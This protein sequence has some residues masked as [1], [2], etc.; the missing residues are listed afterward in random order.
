MLNLD[1][2][3]FRDSVERTIMDGF[4]I[5]SEGQALIAEISDGVFGVRPS[6]GAAGEVFA[7]VSIY[8]T[9]TTE[10]MPEVVDGAVDVSLQL[11]LPHE[12]IAGSLRV[13][14]AAGSTIVVTT[15]YTIAGKVITLVSG[16]EGD[17]IQ[18]RYKF[19]PSV[20]EA[21]LLQGD[22]APG[23]SASAFL[24]QIGVVERG[25]VYTTEYDTAADWSGVNPAVKLGAGGLFTTAGS[26]VAVDCYVIQ[27]PTAA[28]PTLG[29]SLQ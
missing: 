14:N 18:A 2:S 4:S 25:D 17:V 5:A 11:T 28:D 8:Q 24:S 29:L 27:V 10:V 21:L 12:P 26:G 9:T 15:G 1:K 7:G 16:T 23:H 6:T 13:L 20:Q 19:I 22:Q 3:R